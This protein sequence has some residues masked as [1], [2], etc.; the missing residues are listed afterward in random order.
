MTVQQYLSET[1]ASC[2]EDQLRLQ[3]S[4]DDSDVTDLNDVIGACVVESEKRISSRQFVDRIRL[5]TSSP[6]CDDDD[7]I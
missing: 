2:C 6:V 3:T 4:P 5:L 7:V 1:N